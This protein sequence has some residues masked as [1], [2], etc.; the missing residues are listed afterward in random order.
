L[1]VGRAET[2]TLAAQWAQVEASLL[3][4]LGLRD[5]GAGL[6]THSLLMLARATL[7]QSRLAEAESRLGEAA[8]LAAQLDDPAINAQL[9]LLRAEVH[10]AAGRGPQALEQATASAAAFQ[11]LVLSD[12]A[13]RAH[14]TAAAAARAVNNPALAAREAA[15][16]Q[17]LIERASEQRG[18]TAAKNCLD[19][20]LNR[21]YL[22]M[23]AGVPRP[24]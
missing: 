22:Q 15:A 1:V 5:L 10:L 24:S 18:G 6:R 13:W 8:A 19:L 3:P 4:L 17:S 9:G 2:A 20:P 21:I 11:A 14:A 12:S 7:R 23:I 16:A